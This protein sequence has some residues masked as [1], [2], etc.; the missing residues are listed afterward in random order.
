MKRD[1][2]EH[3]RRQC[4]LGPHGDEA[5]DGRTDSQDASQQAFRRLSIDLPQCSHLHAV[6]LPRHAND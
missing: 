4:S 1:E 5:P 2:L 6:G 3:F